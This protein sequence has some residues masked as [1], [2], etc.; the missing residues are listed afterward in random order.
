MPALEKQSPN[1]GINWPKSAKKFM[2]QE[3]GYDF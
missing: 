1:F 2:E 3:N